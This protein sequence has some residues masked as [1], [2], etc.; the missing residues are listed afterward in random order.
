VRVLLISHYFP[1]EI[2][3]ASHLFYELAVGLRENGHEVT[4]LTG[5]PRYNVSRQV[6]AKYRGLWRREYVDGVEVVR[7]RWPWFSRESMVGRG[8]EHFIAAAAMGL[9]AMAIRRHDVTLV[10]S[11]PLTL[12]IA[13]W[14]LQGSGR[15]GPFVLNVQDLFPQSAIDLGAMKSRPQVAFFRWLERRLYG[16]AAC[17]TVHSPGN[18]KY[19]KASAGAGTPVVVAPN[20]VDPQLFAPQAKDPQLLDAANLD[21]SFVVSFAG[22]MGLSQDMDVIIRAASLLR[23]HEDIVFLLVGDGICKADARGLAEE[24]GLGNVR[25]LP[26]QPREKYPQ[27]L[28][29]SDVSLVTLKRVVQTPVVP[30]KLL[31]IMASGRPA[32]VAMDPGGDAPRVVEQAQCGVCVPPEDPERMAEAITTLHNDRALSAQMG[33]NGRDYAREH[34]SVRA[35][36]RIY[37]GILAGAIDGDLAMATDSRP[38]LPR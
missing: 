6:S 15:G 11:P 36:A 5:F 21:G 30:S 27:V 35:C 16:A 25:W 8:L 23:R 12:G 34:F 33:R 18:A 2:G 38:A 17:V 26:M 4:V 10:Y 24:L 1:P 14:A 20:W 28:A 19:V 31:S 37:E 22:T 29:T 7:A 32:I 9:R 3:T 13:A